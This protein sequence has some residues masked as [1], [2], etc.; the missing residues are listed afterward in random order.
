[1]LLQQPLQYV[2]CAATLNRR[3]FNGIE[4]DKYR[5]IAYHS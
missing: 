2:K 1:L 5:L 3:T 4:R